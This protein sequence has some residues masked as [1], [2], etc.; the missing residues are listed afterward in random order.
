MVTP[1]QLTRGFVEEHSVRRRVP[2]S[3]QHTPATRG[4]L[5][6]IPLGKPARYVRCGTPAAKARRYG[7]QCVHNVLWDP[8]AQHDRCGENVILLH[9]AL[10]VGKPRP[11]PVER[12]HL[13]ARALSKD[14]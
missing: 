5:E 6:Q 12:A 2:G 11:E 14:L 3:V 13:G 9:L 7:A 10:V 1:E 4:K 8:V